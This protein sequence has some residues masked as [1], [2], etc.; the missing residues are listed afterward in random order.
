MLLL[1]MGGGWR[2]RGVY[3]LTICFRLI[4]GLTEEKGGDRVI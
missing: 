4:A 2:G 3:E 1:C